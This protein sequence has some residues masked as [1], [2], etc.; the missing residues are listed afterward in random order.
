MPTSVVASP[1]IPSRSGHGMILDESSRNVFVFGGQ[2]GSKPPT[3]DLWT[4]SLN[5]KEITEVCRDCSAVGGPDPGVSQRMMIEPHLKELYVYV[6]LGPL[7]FT[8]IPLLQIDG[9]VKGP[10]LDVGLRP[11]HMLGVSN[12]IQLLAQGCRTGYWRDG[13]R[14]W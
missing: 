4:F 2:R 5:S 14:W 6:L 8:N 12:D 9:T 13:Y 10:R 1:F 3:S 7:P 11:T